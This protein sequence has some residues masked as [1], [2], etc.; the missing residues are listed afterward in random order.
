MNRPLVRVEMLEKRYGDIVA[1]RDVSFEV[2]RGEIFGLLGPNGA[3]KTTTLECLEGLRSPDRGRIEIAGLDPARNGHALGRAIGVQLQSGSYP[4]GMRVGEAMRFFGAYHRI[5]PRFDLLDRLGLGRKMSAQYREL[6]VGQQRRL[7]LALAIGHRPQV[8]FLDEP[9]AGLDVESRNQL[10]EL[11]AELRSDGTAILMA[12]HDMAEAEKLADRIAI[13]LSGRIAS[14]GTPLDVTAAG[15][16]LTKVSVR[17]E[18]GSLLRSNANAIP[19]VERRVERDG[20]SIFFSTNPGRS[21]SAILD[22]LRA[23]RDE[24]VDLRVE[25]PSLEDRFIEITAANLPPDAEPS[26]RDRMDDSAKSEV[27]AGTAGAQDA[28][29]VNQN[30]GKQK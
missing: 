13:L 24:L 5:A 29:T 10:H 11:V 25:R 9:T 19:S 7:S 12:T 16:G 1:V 15:A 28:T 14:T 8:L 4:P 17:S 22:S 23:S 3:G 2:H 18:T 26:D 20:Y 21:V 30:G 6:S 27:R